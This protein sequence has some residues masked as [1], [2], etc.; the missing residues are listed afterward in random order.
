MPS[1]ARASSLHAMMAFLRLPTTTPPPQPATA[2]TA[3]PIW[4]ASSL[5]L[6][7]EHV[8]ATMAQVV[9]PFC[10]GRMVRGFVLLINVSD[11]WNE[12]Q[13]SFYYSYCGSVPP[14]AMEKLEAP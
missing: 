6:P 13:T 8:P 5:R 9:R 14:S 10:P 1:G 12:Y 4:I 3:V 2:P 7:R 11:Y